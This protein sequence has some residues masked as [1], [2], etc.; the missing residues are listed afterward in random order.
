MCYSNEQLTL[1]CTLERTP[2]LCINASPSAVSITKQ[3]LNSSYIQYLV[4]GV[5]S[6]VYTAIHSKFD[7]CAHPVHYIDILVYV[8]ICSIYAMGK[9][10]KAYDYVGMWAMRLLI[11]LVVCCLC[12]TMLFLVFFFKFFHGNFIYPCSENLCVLVLFCQLIRLKWNLTNSKYTQNLFWK[13]TKSTTW[14]R[15][16]Q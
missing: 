6:S 13:M 15:N 7:S 16:T 4:E 2:I 10:P 5:V 11:C 3:H 1:L 14:R 12:Y 9:S 8:L